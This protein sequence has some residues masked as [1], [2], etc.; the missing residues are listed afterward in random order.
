MY[1]ISRI[2]SLGRN[3]KFIEK[4]VHILV[5]FFFFFAKNYYLIIA[6]QNYIYIYILYVSYT[7]FSKIN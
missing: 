1:R 3:Y 2:F 6:W 4:H 7:V 5:L